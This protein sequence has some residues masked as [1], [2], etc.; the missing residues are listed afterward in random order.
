MKGGRKLHEQIEQAIRQHEN[1]LVV[2][3]KHSMDSEWIKTEIHHARHQ[4]MKSGRRLL[5]PIALV[6]FETI[7]EW[8]A[9]DADVGKDMA[10]EVREYSIPDFSNWKDHDAY[11]KAFDRLIRDLEAETPSEEK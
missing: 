9:L 1:L 7:S 11:Q 8:R 3:S 10:R 5:Y 4:E 2:L 6:D